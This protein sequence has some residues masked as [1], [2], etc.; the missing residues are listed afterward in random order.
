MSRVETK[1]HIMKAAT[2]LP[3]KSEDRAWAD[4][5]IEEHWG[6]TRVISRKKAYDISTLPGF[7]ADVEGKKAGL[8]TYRFD[9][10]ECELMT[11]NSLIE[12][13]GV[14]TALV[15][16][17]R[18]AAIDNGCTRLWLITTNDN[19]RALGFYQKRGFSLVAVHSGAIE[20]SRK[21]KPQIPMIGMHGIPLR[22]ELELEVLL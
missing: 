19:M 20:Y 15:E 3:L 14:G 10:D 21:L 12:D 5:L 16:A 6:S 1:D 17:V 7:V 2:V 4:A 22:D 13:A 9:G 11:L 8:A 18:K